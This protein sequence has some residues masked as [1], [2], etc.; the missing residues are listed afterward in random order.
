MSKTNEN[1]SLYQQNRGFIGKYASLW[2]D[3]MEEHYPDLVD[4]MWENG[5]FRDVMRS[6]EDMANEY[7]DL[8]DRQ[9]D[10]THPRPTCGSF[11]KIVSWEYTREFYTDSATMRDRVLYPRTTV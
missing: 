4:E 3:W 5:T 11:E 7:K 9:Y 1:L 10:E 6:V 2:E 8:L